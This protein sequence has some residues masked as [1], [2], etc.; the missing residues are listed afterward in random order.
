[1]E[2]KIYTREKFIMGIFMGMERYVTE[3]GDHFLE[4]STKDI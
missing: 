2:I 3:M 1:M 4:T